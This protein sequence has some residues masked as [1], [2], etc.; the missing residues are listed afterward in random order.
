MDCPRCQTA[1]PEGA[2]FCLN[3]GTQLEAP[4]RLDGERKYVTVLFAD[5][6]DSTVMAERL[7]PEQFAITTAATT[8]GPTWRVP[9]RRWP[10]G[11]SSRI[12]TK[13]Q[14]DRAR[15][16]AALSKNCPGHRFVRSADRRS[17]LTSLRRP[18]RTG[19]E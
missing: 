19:A 15:R 8:C 1:N 6:V 18:V 11:T 14:T 12:A 13:R 4:V 5:V 3:C 9:C 10:T 2:R 17:R 7:D 16:P